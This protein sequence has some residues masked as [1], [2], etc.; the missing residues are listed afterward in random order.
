MN[1][2]C[3]TFTFGSVF[4]ADETDKKLTCV[5]LL[6]RAGNKITKTSSR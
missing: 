4:E 5:R 6:A 2:S 3:G 1:S